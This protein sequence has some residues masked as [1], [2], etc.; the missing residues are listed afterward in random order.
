MVASLQCPLLFRLA[1]PFYLRYGNAQTS[2]LVPAVGEVVAA[3]EPLAA[4]GRVD[5]CLA[6]GQHIL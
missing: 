2:M 3:G 4:C 1:K 5:L 6:P